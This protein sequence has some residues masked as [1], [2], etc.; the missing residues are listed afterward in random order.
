M[1]EGGSIDNTSTAR[2]DAIYEVQRPALGFRPWFAFLRRALSR[3]FFRRFDMYTRVAA[4]FGFLTRRPQGWTNPHF[5]PDR[6]DRSQGEGLGTSVA[7]EIA[8]METAS[9]P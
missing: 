4:D 9:G 7:A 2:T 8:G 1:N 5:C 6:A 3:F